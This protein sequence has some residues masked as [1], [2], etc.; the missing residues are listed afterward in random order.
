MNTS[1]NPA[2]SQQS[3]KIQLKNLLQPILQRQSIDTERTLVKELA[4]ELQTDIL[5]CAA[6]LLVYLNQ[7]ALAFKQV[8]C[9]KAQNTD[10]LTSFESIQ[11]GTKMVRYRLD[12]GR[13]NQVTVEDLK[14]ILVEESGVDKNNIRN[15][16]IQPDY[17][18][19]ELPDKM[20]LDI[21]Q[22]LKLV[23]INHHKL[24]IKRVKSRNNKKRR[25]PCSRQAQQHKTKITNDHEDKIVIE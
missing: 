25:N 16:N 4:A 1:N 13:K 11:A 19:I 24:N 14:K 12:V 10:K 20:P 18:L 9:Y 7:E 2:V 15:V 22:H 23:E 21:F 6:A 3:I 8:S 17:T 5:D